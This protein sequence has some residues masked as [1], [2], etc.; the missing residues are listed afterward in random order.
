M[1]RGGWGGGEGCLGKWCVF[2]AIN[3]HIN[4]SQRKIK[5]T[6]NLFI[7]VTVR[8]REQEMMRGKR[9]SV[10]WASR[11]EER[12]GGE[13]RSTQREKRRIRISCTVRSI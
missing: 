6:S 5:S 9:F 7:L 8:G 4:I 12:R 1:E 13:G 10:A 3:M 2:C 11:G